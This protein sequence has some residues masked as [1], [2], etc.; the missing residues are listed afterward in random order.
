MTLAEPNPATKRG[1]SGRYLRPPAPLF[2]PEGA[3][4]PEGLD[5]KLKLIELFQSVMLALGEGALVGSDMFLYWDPTNPRKC[6]APDL[7]VRMGSPA[8]IL[9]TWKTW[10][11]G[12]PHVGVEVVSDYD[13]GDGPFGE[14]LERYR[15][16]GIAEVVRF[17]PEARETPLRLWDLLDG[18]LVERDLSTP[19]ARVCD[20]L[21]FYWCVVEDAR[22][23]RKL[24]LAR[25]AK[26]TDLLP[27]PEESERA[28]KEAALAAKEAAL[29]AKEAALAAKEA[30]LARIA[31][32][33]EKLAR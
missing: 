13:R 31:E 27:T 19:E 16:A 9:K 15:Q 8:L 14:K 20:A 22:L 10:E 21:G 1:V 4:V 29:A 32:L 11:Q 7:C 24:R 3:D 17:D 23:G 33:E 30:A 2:F 25:D 18:D 26:G 28:A 12:A 5:H 6:L